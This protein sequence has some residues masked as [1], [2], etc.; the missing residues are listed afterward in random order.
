MTN[1]EVE[2]LKY[3]DLLLTYELI[4]QASFNTIK[5]AIIYNE[6]HCEKRIENYAISGHFATQN[7]IKSEADA[8]QMQMSKWGSAS[9]QGGIALFLSRFS[10]IERD[11]PQ[12]PIV[13]EIKS[14]L[15]GGSNWLRDSDIPNDN[16]SYQDKQGALL[17]GETMSGQ[18]LYFVGEGALVS[19]APPGSGKTQ[20][21]VF[22]NLLSYNG[23]CI[24]LDVKGECFEK[25]AHWRKNNVG[26][27]Y[28]FSP[29]DVDASARYNPLSIIE[30][31]PETLWEDAR[32]L[33]DLLIVPEDKN[34]PSWEN[35]ARDVVAGVIAWL[36]R[37]KPS[38][39]RKMGQVV[40]VVSK[41]GWDDFVDDAR[42]TFEIAPLSRLGNSLG[43]M[44]EKQL[45][46]VLDAAR[47]HLAVWE[48]SRVEKVTSESSWNP[49]VL[50]DGSN[51]TIYICIPPN[52]IEAYAPLLR[53]V[54][55]QHL[56][57]LMHKLPR[58]GQTPILFMLDELPRLG[59]MKPVEEALEVGRQY[60]IKLWMFAQSL[61]QFE[62][63]Y[64]N[65]EGMLGSCAVRIYMNPSSHD[66]TA[67]RISEELGFVESLLDGSRLP[68]VDPS[69]LTGPEFKDWQ[70]VFARD[71]RPNKVRKL[72]AYA[73]QPFKGR[74]AP[75]VP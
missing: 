22:P 54:F 17:I 21:N 33:A 46:G 48:G 68:M 43:V 73:Q 2:I 31:D 40:D 8:I 5:I 64:A 55:A 72:F 30:N 50:R 45:E 62:K 27:I 70:I 4:D 53:V 67:K 74:L 59:P 42:S 57:V 60:G 7:G 75:G 37:H 16:F 14:R 10:G 32:L 23:P 6:G 65:A 9:K 29:L 58:R 26:P 71:T 63:S 19:I 41:I 44:P 3:L 35:R 20:C 49:N 36:V 56:R 18:R 34:D 12:F 11:F 28:R 66:G 25:T 38:S 1:G 69:A 51:A 39:E 13:V 15:I 47:R 52:Q 61:G 24:V